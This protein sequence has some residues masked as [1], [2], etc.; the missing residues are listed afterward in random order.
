MILSGHRVI[1]RPATAH[2]VD[3]LTSILHEPA[4]AHRW[5]TF[6]EARVAEEF[7]GDDRVFIVEVD[8]DAIGSIQYSEENDPM[9]RH[10][11]IDIFL[12]STR[13]RQGFGTDAIRTL[14]R[15][16]FDVR[17]HHRLTIDPAADNE[18]AIKAYEK[19]GFHRVGIMR[20]YER[21]P[22]G[23]WHDG[24]L[25]D[26]LAEELVE[27]GVDARQGGVVDL[28]RPSGGAKSIALTTR[29]WESEGSLV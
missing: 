2:D 25:M 10:A 13:H 14:A 18:A 29:P 19:V 7:V 15:Y 6:D 24:L 21:G 9:Y 26:M 22:D 12:T 28:P 11:A 23:T 27:D 4:V 20:A 16:L 3:R 5:G 17:G 1:L 8:G